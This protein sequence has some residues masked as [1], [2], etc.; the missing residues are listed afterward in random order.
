M[1]RSLV[2][3]LLLVNAAFF[4]WSHGW[5]NKVIGVQPDAQ[6]EPQRMG[7][8]VQAD[9]IV[10]IAPVAATAEASGQA[11]AAAASQ[12]ASEAS[13][14]HG[15]AGAAPNEAGASGP[16]SP[17]AEPSGAQAAAEGN[18]ACVEAG[19]FSTNE[20]AAVENTLKAVLPAGS[21]AGQA[22]AIQGLWLVYMGP[23][24]DQDL[25][26]HKQSE[27]RHIK[28]LNF[29]EVRTPA[30]LA[31]GLSL[32]RYNRQAEAEAALTTLRNRGIRTARVVN[33]RP[34]MEVQVVR[35]AHTNQRIQLTLSNLKLPQGKGFSAC[36]P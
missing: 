4:A 28:G 34:D 8:Q 9:K 1:L 3:I 29:E 17:A 13:S 31:Q 30:S 23:Y 32:G 2:L 24:P 12:A 11:A 6:H 21:W 18:G 22:V 36:R 15:D 14:D 16:S 33:V 35:I 5:L 25:F 20:Y 26:A 19:P 7:L 27:L 10:V